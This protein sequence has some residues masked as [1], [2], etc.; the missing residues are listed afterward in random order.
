MAEKEQDI[1]SHPPSASRA[2]QT[3]SGFTAVPPIPA[4]PR[5]ISRGLGL[6]RSTGLLDGGASAGDNLPPGDTSVAH[7][8]SLL[9]PSTPSLTV[10]PV[11]MDSQ[12]PA[13]QRDPRLDA[14]IGGM[15]TGA[16]PVGPKHTTVSV[17]PLL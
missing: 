8:A 14:T 17:N 4:L 12:P 2:P 6:S 9:P 1:T 16:G 13:G 11:L 5:N 15:S 3:P 7:L 10:E